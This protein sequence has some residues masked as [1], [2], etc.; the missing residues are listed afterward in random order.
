[1]A[2]SNINRISIKSWEKEKNQVVTFR[3]DTRS[4]NNMGQ[5]LNQRPYYS[6]WDEKFSLLT[7]A[8][9]KWNPIC[10]TKQAI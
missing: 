1:M 6:I 4:S 2:E 8:T 7:F 10:Q 9:R 3:L 5:T